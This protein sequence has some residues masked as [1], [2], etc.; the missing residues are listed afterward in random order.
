MLAA[1]RDISRLTRG[2]PGSG[3]AVP[4]PAGHAL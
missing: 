1:W 4:G 3:P 2:A